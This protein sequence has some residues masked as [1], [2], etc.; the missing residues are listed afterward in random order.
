MQRRTA[1]RSAAQSRTFSL[2]CRTPHRWR[3][4]AAL[5]RPAPP[6]ATEAD[7]RER[8]KRLGLPEELTEEEKEAERQKA[9]AKAAEEA[10]RKLPVKPI[11]G[12]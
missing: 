4:L 3:L 8:R 9:A 5:P 1:Q 10:R 6:D 2:P 7:R 11:T 12:L